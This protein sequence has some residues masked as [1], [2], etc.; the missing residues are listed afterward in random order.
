[1]S[2]VALF[3][4]T[5]S[6]SSLNVV[7]KVD[8]FVLDENNEETILSISQLQKVFTDEI[9]TIKA[10]TKRL[11]GVKKVSIGESSIDKKDLTVVDPTRSIRVVLWGNYC[12]KEVVKDNTY[13]FKRFRYRSNK[14]GNYIIRLKMV[15]S[16]WKSVTHSNK[17]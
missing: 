11:N 12:E 5:N 9:V 13:I 2:P 7:V 16:Q 10:I 8:S 17:F 15:S 14:F 4:T 6:K 1:M 3:S